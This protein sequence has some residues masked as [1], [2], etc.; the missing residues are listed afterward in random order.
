MSL[1]LMSEPDSD[2]GSK[3]NELELGTWFADQYGQ[4]FTIALDDRTSERRVFCAGNFANP[5]IPNVAA[6]YISVGK[7]LMPGTILQITSIDKN[8]QGGR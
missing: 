8:R 1:I 4:V 7:I 2:K 3:A 5:F 6:H